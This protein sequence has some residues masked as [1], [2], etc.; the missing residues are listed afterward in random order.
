MR[1]FAAAA[2]LG[3]LLAMPAQAAQPGCKAQAAEMRLSGPDREAFIAR[4]KKDARAA[5]G[6][7]VPRTR[8][9]SRAD[10]DELTR[11]MSRNVLRSIDDQLRLRGK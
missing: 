4:C 11:A 6:T 8:G 5:R 10:E 3:A 1:Y 2:A 7:S 9:L